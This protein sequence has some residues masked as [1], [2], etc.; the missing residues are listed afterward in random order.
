MEEPAVKLGAV[1][2]GALWGLLS[3]M[4]LTALSALFLSFSANP[5]AYL[6]AAMGTVGWVAV[7]LSG[8][9]AG[10]AAGRTGLLHGALAGLLFMAAAVSLGDL[11]FDVPIVLQG[12]LLRG[13][14]AVAIGA[15]GGALGVA[16]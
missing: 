6:G 8:V 11:L 9:F 3:A 12:A 2:R 16:L 14:I 4:I 10:R 15:A 7:L 13:L 1:G 5:A